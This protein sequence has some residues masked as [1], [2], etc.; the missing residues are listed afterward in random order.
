MQHGYELLGFLTGIEVVY[1][2]NTYQAYYS[3][4]GTE[5]NPDESIYLC[6]DQQGALI[7]GV[8]TLNRATLFVP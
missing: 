7:P 5:Q 4:W 8:L 6:P 1:V 2:D 3:A